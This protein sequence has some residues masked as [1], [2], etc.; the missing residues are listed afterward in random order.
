MAAPRWVGSTPAPLR[1]TNTAD[2][3]TDLDAARRGSST[4]P[5]RRGTEQALSLDSA[6]ELGRNLEDQRVPEG[7]HP[8]GWKLGFTNQALWSNIGLDR[9]ICARIYRETLCAGSLETA[10]LVQ[11]RIEHEIVVAI[12]AD[13]PQGSDADTIAAAIEWVAAVLL[14]DGVLAATGHGANVLGGPVNALD[15]LLR[16]LPSGLR[17]GEI[18]T[19]GTVTEALPVEPGQHWTHCLTASVAVEPAELTFR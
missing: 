16:G 18:V 11:P 1:L 3:A 4:I 14:R 15:W 19:T 17:A 10:Q 5:S 8:A 13:L 7:W 2:I 6:Y 9:P 12:G